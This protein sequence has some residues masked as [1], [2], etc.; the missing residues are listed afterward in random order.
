[1]E[2]RDLPITPQ[3]KPHPLTQT[4]NERIRVCGY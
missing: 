4:I 1:M 2:I 3:D